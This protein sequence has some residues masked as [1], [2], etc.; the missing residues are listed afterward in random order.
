MVLL[1]IASV[2]A[3]VAIIIG[4]GM[5]E[6]IYTITIQVVQVLYSYYFCLQIF[7]VE[8]HDAEVW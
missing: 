7:S 3:L 8:L 6:C 4:I 5:Y 1:V 2:V